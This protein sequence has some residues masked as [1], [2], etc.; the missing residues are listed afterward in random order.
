MP[1]IDSLDIGNRALQHCGAPQIADPAEDSKSNQEVAFAYDKLRR[2]EL[3]RNVWRFAIRKAALRP[4]DTTTMLLSPPLYG[5]TSTYLLGAIVRDSNGQF[6]TSLIPDN[7]GNAPGG[8]NEAWDAYFGPMS[9]S[10]WDGTQSYFA[11]ELIYIADPNV[12]GGYQVYT[13]LKTSNSDVP[14]LATP[15]DAAAT[16][17]A[18]QVVSYGLSNW[19]SLIP[20]NLNNTPADGAASWSS[21][22]SYSIGNQ[23]TDDNGRVYQSAANGNTGHK[24]STDDGTNWTFA[25]TYT[26][27]CRTPTLTAAAASWRSI[28]DVGLKP[29]SILYPLGCGPS[30]DVTTRNVYRLPAGYLR[31]APQNAKVP[32]A[33][34]GG[35]RG[36]P[37]NDWEIDGDFIVTTE[38]SIIVFRFVADVMTVR[39]MDDM[40]CEGLACRIA[41]AV[42]EPL[43]QSDG[44]LQTI[45]SAYKTFMGEARMVNALEEGPEDPPDDEF[46]ACRL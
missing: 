9:V 44:K 45:A 41:T 28:G 26:P 25:G 14:N 4:V 22:T 19:R 13:S 43:T 31:T 7:L 34:L 11:G 40:F 17:Y 27:W 8:N 15:W 46:I 6:W 37:E 12:V 30:S 23:V 5:A 29:L 24:P 36:I 3:R 18:D 2:A 32:V 35:P 1:F 16:Y 10:L 42:C 20:F 39:Q 33:A 21:T 38:T